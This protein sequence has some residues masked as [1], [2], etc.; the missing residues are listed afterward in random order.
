MYELQTCVCELV[1]TE[2]SKTNGMFDGLDD[3]IVGMATSETGVTLGRLIIIH[4]NF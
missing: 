1:R 4:L 3:A 2:N